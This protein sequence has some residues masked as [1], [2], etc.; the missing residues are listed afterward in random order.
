MQKEIINILDKIDILDT[1]DIAY[2][3]NMI[4]SI[5]MGKKEVNIRVKELDGIYYVYTFMRK[6]TDPSDRFIY[7]KYTTNNRHEIIC[8]IIK[9]IIDD[10]KHEGYGA[11]ADEILNQ[12]PDDIVEYYNNNERFYDKIE[13]FTDTDFYRNW[14]VG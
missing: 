12:L 9:Y 7:G 4:H 6:E 1:S 2:I 10:Y 3:S 11:I 14:V 13:V 8:I 5:L